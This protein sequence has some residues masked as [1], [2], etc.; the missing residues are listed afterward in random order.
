M[1]PNSLRNTAAAALLTIATPFAANADN[2]VEPDT[3]LMELLQQ[4]D[5][6]ELNQ[7]MFMESEWIIDIE[8]VNDGNV[9]KWIDELYKLARSDDEHPI[10]VRLLESPGGSTRDGLNFIDALHAVPNPVV[11]LCTENAHSMGGTILYSL[12]NGIRL[13]TE[14]CNIMTH[15][16]FW[17]D[18]GR[19]SFTDLEN[20]LDNGRRNRDEM[21]RITAEASG[22]TLNDSAQLYTDKD[23]HLTPRQALGAG[24]IDAIIPHRAVES[25]MQNRVTYTTD[26]S[27]ISPATLSVEVDS[28]ASDFKNMFCEAVQTRNVEYCNAD[29]DGRTV[30]TTEPQYEEKEVRTNEQ[31]AELQALPN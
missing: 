12:R 8:S 20:I 29:N 9:D 11:A 10:V 14:N 31:S 19:Q 6:T 2:P 24:L 1:F 15:E 26:P 16:P 22:L 25:D 30:I 5:M 3:E 13:S 17:P 21:I 4:D 7:L 18:L 28:N 23:L 27:G